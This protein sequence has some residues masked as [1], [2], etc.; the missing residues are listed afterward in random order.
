MQSR[1]HHRQGILHQEPGNLVD[2]QAPY[3]G[4]S[5]TCD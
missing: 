5:K 4:L 2:N 1:V 3:Q